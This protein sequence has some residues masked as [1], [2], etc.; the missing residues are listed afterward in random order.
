MHSVASNVG[1]ALAKKM[2]LIFGLKEIDTINNSDI[3]D[4]YKDLYL[5]EKNMKKSC[6]KLY[7]QQ[8]LKGSGWCKKG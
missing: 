3:Y 8:W 4:T 5:S 2:V 7:K 1:R 6:F